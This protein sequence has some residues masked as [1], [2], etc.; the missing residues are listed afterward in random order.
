MKHIIHFSV[1]FVLFALAFL[2]QPAFPA[3]PPAPAEL[4]TWWRDS[5]VVRV[6]QLRDNQIRQIEQA[7]LNRRAEL[8]TLTDELQRQNAVLQ[9]IIDTSSLDDKRAEAQIEQVV[10][11]RAR[12]EKAKSLMSL[13]IRRAV[14]FDQWKKLQELQRVQTA[15][16][17]TSASA[18]ASTAGRAVPKAENAAP[19]QEEPVYQVGGPVSSP[20]EIQNPMPAITPEA[21]AK[22]I[23]GSVLLSIVIGKDGTVRNVKV[24]RGLGYG[25]D[26][27]A[28]ETVTRKWLFKPSMLNG[29]PVS[30]RADME[31]TFRI[32]Q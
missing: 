29:Q 19:P 6:L 8:S 11:T 24:L 4:G 15:A 1:P 32:R 20:V 7:F 10:T 12:L 26:E 3:A 27:S 18:P 23:S 9:S 5:E 17:S 22:Q 2:A 21:R 25:L 14:T 13:E 28:A 31:V 16:L 30:V